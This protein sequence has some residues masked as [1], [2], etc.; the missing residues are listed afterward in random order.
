MFAVFRY[1]IFPINRYCAGHYD[2]YK[3]DHLI[4]VSYGYTD[5]AEN[6]MS[7]DLSIIL[8]YNTKI[9]HFKLYFPYE[10]KDFTLT[11]LYFFRIKMHNR[12]ITR[13]WLLERCG[14]RG[15]LCP[16]WTAGSSEAEFN[17][18]PFCLYRERRGS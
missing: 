16:E 7:N 9:N 17:W 3:T 13:R 5:N 1:E 10:E 18:R 4:C 8:S 12:L 2:K 6:P 15:R 11:I 14:E